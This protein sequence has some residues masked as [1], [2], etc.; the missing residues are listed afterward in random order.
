MGPPRRK[1]HKAGPSHKSSSSPS[2]LSSFLK[3]CNWATISK[4]IFSPSYSWVAAIC[5]LAAEFVLNIV[6]IHRV[7]YTEIDWVAYM[8]EVEGVSNG[9]FDYSQLRGDTGPLVYPAGFVWFY[10]A[11]YY[12][13]SQG[14]NI[15]LAQ[16]SLAV[17]IAIFSRFLIGFFPSK[18]LADF[19]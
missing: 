14:T 19:K 11:L 17:I 8:Q 1:S 7:K 13:T 16:G 15:L 3:T 12:I 10:M 18:L 5:L 4:L 2:Y 6:V 9:T